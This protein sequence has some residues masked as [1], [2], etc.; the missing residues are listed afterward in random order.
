MEIQARKEGPVTVVELAGDLDTNTAPEAQEQILPLVEDGSRLLLDV[1]R[2][3]YMSSAGLRVMLSLYRRVASQNGELVLVG[4]SEEIR[5]TM[6]VTG[7]LGFFS[8]C[9][10]YEAGLA[11]LQEQG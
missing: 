4:L 9:Q 6:E 2:V 11:T 3:P 8:T 5:D 10:T 1:S 7:F